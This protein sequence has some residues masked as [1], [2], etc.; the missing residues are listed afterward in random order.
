MASAQPAARPAPHQPGRS[1][2]PASTT[3]TCSGWFGSAAFRAARVCRVRLVRQRRLAAVAARCCAAGTPTRSRTPAGRG[4]REKGCAARCPAVP[5]AASCAST[6]GRHPA[7]WPAA[8][9]SAAHRRRGRPSPSSSAA[10]M[11]GNDQHLRQ[12]GGGQVG[13]DQPLPPLRRG[14]PG[15]GRCLRQRRR[16]WCRSPPAGPP[17]RPGRPGGSGR[18]ASSAGQP[19]RF[20]PGVPS[21][22]TVQ[23]TCCSRWAMT[24]GS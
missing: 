19:S 1:S 9:R 8:P 16:Q 11:N 3:A 20:R 14:Q 13:G 12:A 10:P 21:L 17:P 5:A 15:A 2:D 24:A 7:G 6:A 4:C 18:D 22:L 23:P